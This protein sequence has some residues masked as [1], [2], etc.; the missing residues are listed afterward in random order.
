MCIVCECPVLDNFYT[1]SNFFTE[2]WNSQRHSDSVH[3]RGRHHQVRAGRQVQRGE[4]AEA[5]DNRGVQQSQ[6]K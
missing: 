2:K 3:G 5:L 4:Q 1:A 6:W